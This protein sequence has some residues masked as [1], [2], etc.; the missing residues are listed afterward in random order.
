MSAADGAEASLARKPDP[1][2]HRNRAKALEA[3]RSLLS[4]RGWDAVTHLAVSERSGFGRTTLY[5]FWPEQADLLHDL[6]E[7]Q[8]TSASLQ[9]TGD[10]RSD[11]L[12]ELMRLADRINDPPTAR[13]I[14]AVIERAAVND[15][16]AE[17]RVRW[18]LAGTS[19]V[20]ALIQEAMASGI[21]DHDLDMQEA[22]DQLAGPMVLRGFFAAVPV[23][24]DYVATCVDRFLAQHRHPI[25]HVDR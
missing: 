3:A 1:R 19:G 12:A 14:L 4:E 22:V 2:P 18:H 24:D 6:L 21:L 25:A 7:S 16:F 17:L 9:T 13:M 23:T 15:Q 10:L 11:L 20:R 8:L 5:R